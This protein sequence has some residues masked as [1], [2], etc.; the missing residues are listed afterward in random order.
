MPTRPGAAIFSGNSYPTTMANRG[1][2]I[3]FFHL[4]SGTSVRFPA[5]LTQFEDQWSSEWNEETVFGRMDPIST[6]KRTMRKINLGWEIA[7][8]S[9]AQARENIANIS[10]LIQMLYPSYDRG[11][12][13]GVAEMT[14]ATEQFVNAMEDREGVTQQEVDA[15]LAHMG[16]VAETILGGGYATGPGINTTHISGPPLMKIRFVNLIKNSRTSSDTSGTSAEITG[17]L[18]Y[19]G[20]F[21]NAPMLDVGFIESGGL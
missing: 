4:V 20:G 15:R 7:A 13:L 6:F 14:A 3:E 12:P 8:E 19:V 9:G 21:T 17:L 16:Q 1:L 11:E 5:F 18:G 2:Y 10:A